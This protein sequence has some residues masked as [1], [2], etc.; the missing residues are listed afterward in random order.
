M[1]NFEKKMEAFRSGK[2][3]GVVRDDAVLITDTAA[4][5]TKL[6]VAEGDALF[7]KAVLQFNR[8]K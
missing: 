2:I 4:N 6:I 3:K 7:S 8:V 5:V 1:R